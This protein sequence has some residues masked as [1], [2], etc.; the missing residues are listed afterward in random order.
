MPAQARPGVGSLLC[1]FMHTH[2]HTQQQQPITHLCAMID[3]IAVVIVYPM[4]CAENERREGRREERKRNDFM[5]RSD[6]CVCVCGVCEVFLDLDAEAENKERKMAS[7]MAKGKACA[8]RESD[9]V[10]SRR[11]RLIAS[12]ER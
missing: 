11:K 2:T 5:T 10:C 9:G 4:C 1:L 8:E 12:E 3:V 6:M 7:D